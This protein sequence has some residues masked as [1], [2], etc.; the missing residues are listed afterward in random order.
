[1]YDMIQY[2]LADLIRSITLDFI[3]SGLNFYRSDQ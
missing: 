2:Y 3:L 1:M